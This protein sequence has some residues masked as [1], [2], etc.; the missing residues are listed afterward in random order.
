MS[1]QDVWNSA[2]LHTVPT[3]RTVVWGSKVRAVWLGEQLGVR[4]VN[5]LD[6]VTHKIINLIVIG[7]GV[8]L[9]EAK[10]WRHDQ[11][12]DIYLIAVPSLWGSGAEASPV[13]VLNR[14]GSKHIR[15][16]QEFLPDARCTLPELVDSIPDNLALFGC[17]D[18]WSHAVEGFLSP[19]ATEW[20]C[21]SLGNLI[22]EMLC[23]PI[24]RDVRWFEVSARASA[25]QAQSS[26]GLIHGIAHTLEGVVQ[27][28]ELGVGWGH[29][30]ICSTFLYPV[31][32]FNRQ[33]SKKF[34][35]LT[36]KYGVDGHAILAIG[37]TIF[38]EEDYSFLLPLLEATWDLVIRDACTR[39]N[40]VLV[41]RHSLSFFS[42]R[43]FL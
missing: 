12:P 37:R 29:A 20:L 27:K 25:G 26:V 28:Q 19:L 30:R 7:G 18:V 2:Q 16:G 40:S 14:D 39:T 5:S 15:I 22:H 10:A 43:N 11:R 8:P 31:M 36:A 17:G 33:A 38:S 34:D 42:Q 23:L 6:Q 13:V 4:A 32:C 3:D 24:D 9:D 21:A 1:R 41:R 35:I